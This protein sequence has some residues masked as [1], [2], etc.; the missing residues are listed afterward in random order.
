MHDSYVKVTFNLWNEYFKKFFHEI[1]DAGPLIQLKSFLLD[2]ITE[3]RCGYITL[4]ISP[5]ILPNLSNISKTNY[6]DY[7]T[8]EVSCSSKQK[9]TE[10]RK[11]VAVDSSPVKQ[12]KLINTRVPVE[13]LKAEKVLI[14]ANEELGFSIFKDFTYK[15]KLFVCNICGKQ[16]NSRPHVSRHVDLLHNPEWKILH[17]TICPSTSNL[18]PI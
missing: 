1:A 16:L 5:I 4:E 17:C 8:P 9:R 15:E 6:D 11:Q 10:N 7:N 13:E 2:E 14:A 18:E 12:L 3:L